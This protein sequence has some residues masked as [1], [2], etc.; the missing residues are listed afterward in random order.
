[1]S[2][3]L[4]CAMT[5][6]T[7][8]ATFFGTHLGWFG[9]LGREERLTRLTFGHATEDQARD[10]LLRRLTE[11]TRV[12]HQFRSR[13]GSQEN[14]GE[15]GSE[16]PA[17]EPWREFDWNPDLRRD[18]E[19]YAAGERVEF[20][21]H[22]LDLPQQTPFQARVQR[23][24]RRVGYGQQATYAEIAAR[25]GSPGAAR[26]VG[27]VMSSNRIPLLIPCHRIIASNGG[28]GGYSAPQGVLLKRQLLEMEAGGLRL[29][30][31]A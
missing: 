31:H 13:E 20:D 7:W 18:L 28:L 11:Q 27:T 9:L 15:H 1:M 19:A 25:V 2:P 6:T 8:D 4:D 23:E 26:A 14:E 17:S 22:K 30:P 21:G 29:V 10:E 24:T 16:T 3:T 12:A 5:I